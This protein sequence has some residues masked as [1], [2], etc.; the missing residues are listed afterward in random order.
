MLSEYRINLQKNPHFALAPCALPT[1]SFK[2]NIVQVIK[3]AIPVQFFVYA[4]LAIPI[5]WHVYVS[6]KEQE[7]K[8]KKVPAWRKES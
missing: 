8:E 4:L 2:M 1:E 7:R 6:Y 5:G 3:D